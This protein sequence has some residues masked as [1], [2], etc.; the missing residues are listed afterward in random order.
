MP[1]RCALFLIL[2]NGYDAT[3]TD[4]YFAAAAAASPRLTSRL[5]SDGPATGAMLY[6][7]GVRLVPRLGDGRR[8]VDFALTLPT[9]DLER[10]ALGGYLAPRAASG[11]HRLAACVADLGLWSILGGSCHYVIKLGATPEVAAQ[12]RRPSIR[13]FSIACSRS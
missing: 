1:A 12:S 13:T 2:T 10:I 6:E 9:V 5:L 8:P 11:E 4:M 7:Q 3:V